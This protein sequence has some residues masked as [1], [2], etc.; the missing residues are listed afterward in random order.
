MCLSRVH[1]TLI[2]GLNKV[3]LFRN[4]TTPK[5]FLTSRLPRRDW[6]FSSTSSIVPNQRISSWVAQ[7]CTSMVPKWWMLLHSISFPSMWSKLAL[8]RWSQSLRK[9]VGDALKVMEVSEN[10]H[11]DFFYSEHGLQ[12]TSMEFL[13]TNAKHS[14]LFGS[15]SMLKTKV[16]EINQ[17]HNIYGDRVCWNFQVIVLGW[18]HTK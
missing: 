18:F 9:I 2:T 1:C 8:L 6:S 13:A 11:Y 15:S 4:I 16:W 5:S 14:S 7:R 12:A 3:Q 10:K 17:C